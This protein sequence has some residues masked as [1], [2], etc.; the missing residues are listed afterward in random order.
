MT[1]IDPRKRGFDP[2][3]PIA[4]SYFLEFGTVQAAQDY[5]WQDWQPQAPSGAGHQSERHRQPPLQQQ[6]GIQHYYSRSDAPNWR[7]AAVSTGGQ[8]SGSSKPESQGAGRRPRVLVLVGLPGSG[9]V[10]PQHMCN[11]VQGC[12]ILQ[13]LQRR[14][15]PEQGQSL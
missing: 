15:R 9:E 7:A 3:Q 2:V 8:I 4:P 13:A 5:C 12:N 14:Q 1:E 11:M 6:H 10:L